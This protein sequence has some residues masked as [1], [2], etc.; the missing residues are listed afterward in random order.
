MINNPICV[1]DVVKIIQFISLYFSGYNNIDLSWSRRF[2]FV[3][4][5]TLNKK[6]ILDVNIYGVYVFKELKRV[7]SN[8]DDNRFRTILTR[9]SFF[10]NVTIR[11]SSR[12]WPWSNEIINSI[13]TCI[14]LSNALCVSKFKIKNLPVLLNKTQRSLLLTS[15]NVCIPIW[16]R[17]ISRTRCEQQSKSYA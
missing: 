6:T 14:I 4:R 3:V 8:T 2:R 5:L 17:S 13:Y 10:K 12:L 1:Y 11:R 16:F 9:S 7:T 15:R